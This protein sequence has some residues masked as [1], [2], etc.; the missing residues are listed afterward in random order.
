[1]YDWELILLI[2][3][4]AKVFALVRIIKENRDLRQTTAAE[5]T[6]LCKFMLI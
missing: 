2:K 3:I 4:G 6:E 1:M 5:T